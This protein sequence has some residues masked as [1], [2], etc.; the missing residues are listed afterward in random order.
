[1]HA[2]SNLALAVYQGAD[3][4]YQLI[5]KI[6]DDRVNLADYTARLQAR[7]HPSS[8]T[9]VIDLETGAGITCG[10]EGTIDLAMDAEATA[11]LPAGKYAYDLELESPSG[12]VVRLVQGQIDVEPE[13]TRPVETP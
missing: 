3:W 2:P 10:S 6:G 9:I 8:A 12:I 1:M 13:V 11:M 5:W 4:D 7:P